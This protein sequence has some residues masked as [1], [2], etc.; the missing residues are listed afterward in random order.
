MQ[1][2][3]ELLLPVGNVESFYAALES[4]ANAIYL[5]LKQF[6]ARR[7]AGNFTRK[8]L[9]V[10]LKL[11]KEKKVRVYVTLNIV[12][13]NSELELLIE[14]LDFLHQAGVDGIIVQDWGVFFIARK[15]FPK[16]KLHASTQMGIHNSLGTNH[17]KK[18][19]FK[20]V[21]LARELT[22]N[23][24]E[25]IGA[26]TNIETEVFIHGALCYS[27]SGMC[28]Y[29]S[30][31]GGWG[32]NRGLCTQPCRR[33]FS[34]N[35]QQ[36]Y[37][38]N[39]KDNQQ[40]AVLP[41]L[42]KSG[43]TA[44]KIEG[45]MK[46]GEYAYRVA[47]AYRLALDKPGHSDEANRILAF[48][49]GREKTTYFTGKKLPEAVSESTATGMPLGKV[50]KVNPPFIYISSKI[51]I[52]PGFRL[53]FKLKTSDRISLK[54]K[55]V[56]KQGNFYQ[57]QSGNKNI[58]FG[59]EVYLSGMSQIKFPTSLPED[60]TVKTF[61]AKYGLKRRIFYDFQKY[62]KPKKQK[63]QV[64]IRIN[65][66]AW[67][68]KIHLNEFDGI[69]LNFSKTIWTRF[70]PYSPFIQK[71][72]NKIFIELPKF[73][74]EKSLPFYTNILEK[75]YQAGIRSILISQ[76]SQKQLVLKGSIVSVNENVYV[77]NEATCTWLKSEGI[78]DFIYPLEVDF[79]TLESF[80]DKS[81]IVPV[82]FY[83]ELFYS[84]MP[85]SKGEP[86]EKLA[87]DQH[88]GLRRFRKDGITSIVPQHPVSWL[89]Y[90]KRLGETGFSRFLIDVSYDFPSKN[91]LKT[92]K[93]R[94]LLSEQV[95]PSTTFNF[96]KELK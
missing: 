50:E 67:L 10:M 91:R 23:E 13:K 34:V 53:R 49:F 90:K 48:D 77:F 26:K 21:V 93:K 30:Y 46:S 85:V 22:L 78:K 35:N 51:E 54:V 65:S 11:A 84:R 37:L 24:L 43:V 59:S 28:L 12:I 88:I 42:V 68:R 66:M 29:S 38:F 7:K 32:A 52:K 47:K 70:D 1:N 80:I 86:V 15:Y 75:M 83:P 72:R 44:L 62:P 41:R 2:W 18:V 36:K 14:H 57:L 16:L 89:Q 20:R 81:G 79:K 56:K 9:L 63:L 73:I 25:E 8:Q 33:S 96:S 92:L 76:L 60:D 71:N 61:S 17:A 31:S 27:F 95:Q 6:N 58:Q 39:L 3:P 19:G 94:L 64:Y 40:L 55:E 45:R 87:D 5:G 74:A 82:Y 69:F 4:G